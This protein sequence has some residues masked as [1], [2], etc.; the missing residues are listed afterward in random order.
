ML[1]DRAASPPAWMPCR[2]RPGAS[3]PRFRGRAHF[4]W[5]WREEGIPHW[6]L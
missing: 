1:T 6:V 2:P 4:A 3:P 5:S